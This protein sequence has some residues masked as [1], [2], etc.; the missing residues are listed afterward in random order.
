VEV[1][2]VGNSIMFE[3]CRIMSKSFF[4]QP[5]M[6]KTILWASYW[7]TSWIEGIKGF[8]RFEETLSVILDFFAQNK[9]QRLVF[10]PHPI[11]REALLA[12]PDG[13]VSRE[14]QTVRNSCSKTN[15]KYLLQELLTLENV[16]LSNSSL[17]QDL[18]LADQ[19]VTD[20]VSLISYWATTG[21][22]MCLIRDQD[23]PALNLS[24]MYLIKKLDTASNFDEI[25]K[26]LTRSASAKRSVK[27]R[28][29]KVHPT[30]NRAPIEEFL[31]KVFQGLEGVEKLE[32]D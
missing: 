25:K 28:S 24:G 14:V 31:V 29:K 13:S 19:L 18:L 22:P 3:L 17:L 27:R 32:S 20:G 4:I 1:H 6:N 15:T 10:R 8:N 9:E 16:V 30:F 2:L 7:S 23:T 21:R 12:L 5:T 26:W 11:L